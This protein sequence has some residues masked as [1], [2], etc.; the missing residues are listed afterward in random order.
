MQSQLSDQTAVQNGRAAASS[1]SGVNQD[2]ELTNLM[3]YQRAFQA[4]AQVVNTV[5]NCLDVVVAGLFGA[6]VA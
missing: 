6:A 1:V 2:E 5:N 4:Q 3:T